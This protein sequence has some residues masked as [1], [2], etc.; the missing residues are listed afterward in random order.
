MGR[1]ELDRFSFSYADVLEHKEEGSVHSFFNPDNGLGTIHLSITKHKSP[2][3]SFNIEDQQ[4]QYPGSIIKSYGPKK[5]L[6]FNSI[7][8]NNRVFYWV[9]GK[10]NQ[11][12]LITYTVLIKDIDNATALREFKYAE[13]IV[14]SI[15]IG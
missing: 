11:M 12:A 3:Y 4:K 6:F 15:K 1:V 9:L 10:A 13:E 14:R 5:A 2:T 8:G 7:V